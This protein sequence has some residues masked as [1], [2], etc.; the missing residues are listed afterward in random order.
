[1]VDPGVSGR[2][3]GRFPKKFSF[4]PSFTLDSGDFVWSISVWSFLASASNSNIL[5]SAS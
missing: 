4:K 3:F 1:M 5:L 2:V